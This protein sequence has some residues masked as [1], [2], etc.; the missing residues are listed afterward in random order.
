MKSLLDI[1]TKEKELVDLINRY[2]EYRHIF[3]N[4]IEEIMMRL[5]YVSYELQEADINRVKS[6][7][8]NIDKYISLTKRELETVRLEIRKYFKELR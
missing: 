7:I 1:L 3:E 4:E 6:R 2:E 8:E 5:D